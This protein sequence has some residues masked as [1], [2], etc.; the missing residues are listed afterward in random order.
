MRLVV[1]W[2][3]GLP[4]TSAV[5]AYEGRQMSLTPGV[6]MAAMNTAENSLVLIV[7]VEGCA[8]KLA[9]VGP[10]RWRPP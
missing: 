1:S 7:A 3:G 10:S 5:I 9:W 6:S 4:I 2:A 8:M